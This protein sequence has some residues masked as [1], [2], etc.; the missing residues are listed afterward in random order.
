MFGAQTID[1]KTATGRKG[2]FR[3]F[4]TTVLRRLIGRVSPPVNF[5][6]NR[7][8]TGGGPPDKGGDGWDAAE[9][10]LNRAVEGLWCGGG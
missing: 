1:A 3:R 8:I 10:G 5:I 9:R 2:R 4:L 6:D 7:R